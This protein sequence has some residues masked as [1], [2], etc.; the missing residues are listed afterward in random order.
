MSHLQD[1]GLTAAT[2]PYNF[3]GFVTTTGTVIS[4]QINAYNKPS[5]KDYTDKLRDSERL[6][7]TLGLFKKNKITIEQALELIATDVQFHK[8]EGLP[9]STAYYPNFSSAGTAVTYT[10]QNYG[11]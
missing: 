4:N 11:F 1:Q 9:A 8:N 3:N 6:R 2:V 10:N 5:F 7:L